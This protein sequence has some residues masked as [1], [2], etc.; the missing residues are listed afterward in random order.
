[1]YQLVI[2]KWLGIIGLIV[3]VGIWQRHDGALSERVVWE[4]RLAEENA[5]AAKAI[6]EAE[7]AARRKETESATRINQISTDY[8]K[9]LSDAHAKYKT[10]DA[11][12]ANGTIRLLDHDATAVCAD[13]SG[14][15]QAATPT[16]GRNGSEGCQLSSHLTGFLWTLAGQADDIATQ[17]TACQ[18][19]VE[20]DRK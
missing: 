6:K 4:T 9:R 7:E 5:N 19:I 10:V 8:Q 2:L 11:G 18:A 1:M 20:A 12:I 14:G 16:S 3:A 15:T 13:Y 17:L